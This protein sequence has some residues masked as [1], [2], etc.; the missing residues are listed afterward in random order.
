MATDAMFDAPA[1]DRSVEVDGLLERLS[2]PQT[3]A[4]LHLLLDNV[5]LLA[6]ASVTTNAGDANFNA[7]VDGDTSGDFIS[8]ATSS[9]VASA[10]VSFSGADATID[11]TITA[12]TGDIDVFS[13]NSTRTIGV[14]GTEAGAGSEDRTRV[15]FRDLRR[16]AVGRTGS[17]Y[18]DRLGRQEPAYRFPPARC[19][20]VRVQ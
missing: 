8:N 14:G 9:V 6:G 12:T 1:N 19:G 7:N 5:E 3:A 2:E 10:N 13:T 17:D 18:Q 15:H 16:K 20:S 4:A 11:G